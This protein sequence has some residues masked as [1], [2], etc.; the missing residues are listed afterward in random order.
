MMHSSNRQQSVT[1]M[2]AKLPDNLLFW[3]WGIGLIITTQTIPNHLPGIEGC[4]VINLI[5]GLPHGASDFLWIQKNTPNNIMCLI[6]CLGYLSIVLLC[7]VTWISFP[8]ITLTIFLALSAYHFGQDWEERHFLNKV[9]VGLGVVSVPYYMWPTAT[10]FLFELITF[11]QPT[12]ALIVTG[13]FY[14]Y[15]TGLVWTIAQLLQQ[16]W[17]YT[18]VLM[19]YLIGTIAQPLTYFTLYFC[20]LHSIRHYRQIAEQQTIKQ[21]QMY[22]MLTIAAFSIGFV[23]LMTHYQLIITTNISLSK[24]GG[25]FILLFALTV[26]HCLIHR[27]RPSSR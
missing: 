5:V 19:L 21:S 3:L 12:P 15:W 24:F 18:E 17:Q 1:E 23:A 26:P 20:G 2:V 7:I 8:S 4:F 22:L 16:R 25:L 14:G 9:I 10:Q 6:G 11:N 13:L 27:L